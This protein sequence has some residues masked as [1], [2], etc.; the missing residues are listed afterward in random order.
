ME[1]KKNE[2]EFIILNTSVNTFVKFFY[3]EGIVSFSK[4]EVSILWNNEK[5]CYKWL[6]E[7]ATS[8]SE[9]DYW[10]FTWKTHFSFL[11]IRK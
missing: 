3:Y 2:D 8:F 6:T 9:M 4:T 7:K 5:I 10:D 11:L 1:K